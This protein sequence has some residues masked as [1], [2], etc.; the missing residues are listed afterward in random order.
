MELRLPRPNDNEAIREI[1]EEGV[2]RGDLKLELPER[3]KYVRENTKWKGRQTSNFRVRIRK[4]ERELR[5]R[6]TDYT[7]WEFNLDIKFQT[8]YEAAYFA[9]RMLRKLFPHRWSGSCYFGLGL[10]KM[11]N[12]IDFGPDFPYLGLQVFNAEN[13]L[14]RGVI[15]DRYRDD[16]PD[17]MREISRGP[18]FWRRPDPRDSDPRCIIK[19]MVIDW[20]PEEGKPYVREWRDLLGFLTGRDNVR[21]EDYFT[22]DFRLMSL[23][24]N[25]I[26]DEFIQSVYLGPQPNSGMGEPV[27]QER[28]EEPEEPE[29]GP[30]R[31]EMPGELPQEPERPRRDSGAL[32]RQR[33]QEALRQRQEAEQG[34]EE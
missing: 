5:Q 19:Q 29:G 24:A 16:I 27:G 17:Y 4:S 23:E 1:M 22:L 6:T 34:E 20:D 10:D 26:G 30:E 33:I 14:G 13:S 32:R 8:K 21:L 28:Q 2:E 18:W 7:E 12:V 15:V 9:H 11:K 31:Q 3:L 25:R